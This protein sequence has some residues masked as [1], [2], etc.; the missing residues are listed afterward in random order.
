MEQISI[1]GCGWLGTPLGEHLSNTGY[2]VLGSTTS[3]N[4]VNELASLGIEPFLFKFNPMP[5]GENFQKLFESKTLFINIPPRSKAQSPEFYREQ[6][7]YLK[8]LL[9]SNKTVEQVIFISSTS[10][11]PN[12]NEEVNEDTTYDFESGS[13]KAVVWAEQEISQIR[14]KLIIL[15]CGGLMGNS[16]IPGRWFAGKETSGKN[17]PTNYIHLDDIIKEVSQLLELEE[18]PKIKN[19]VNPNHY[20]RHEV[21]EAMSAKYGYPPPKWKE[22]FKTPT[23]KVYSKYELRGLTDPLNY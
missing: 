23:K 11:Y 20:P 7:K 8:Y 13:N 12:S 15:R 2:D 17:N 3:E 18:W 22:P 5:E 10:Y 1:I 19:L 16:R 14:Q 4:K 9:S 6:I 21:M